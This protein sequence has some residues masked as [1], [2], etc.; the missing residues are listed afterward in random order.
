M[1]TVHLLYCCISTDVEFAQLRHVI[2]DPGLMSSL[3]S[4]GM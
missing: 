2:S 4:C 3:L 1:G